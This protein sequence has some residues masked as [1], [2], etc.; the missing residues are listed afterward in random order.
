MW[1]SEALRVYSLP[2]DAAASSSASISC[3][4]A[5]DPGAR[6]S[7]AARAARSVAELPQCLEVFEIGRVGRRLH[8]LQRTLLGPKM[9]KPLRDVPQLPD[10]PLGARNLPTRGAGVGEVVLDQRGAAE[11]QGDQCEPLTEFSQPFHPDSLPRPQPNRLS[12]RRHRPRSGATGVLHRCPTHRGNAR[13]GWRSRR[14]RSGGGIGAGSAGAH[15][16]SSPTNP[17]VSSP[18]DGRQTSSGTPSRN[19]F[20]G[21]TVVGLE[22]FSHGHRPTRRAPLPR[23]T[24][25]LTRPVQ[26]GGDESRG[27]AIAGI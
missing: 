9:L 16:T 14:D 3:A 23:S 24:P 25:S 7:A 27:Q 18:S 17:S 21:S 13:I 5:V 4:S 2:S 22:P 1:P 15:P 19:A 26:R 12:A 11:R 10:S 8:H 20:R 6:R